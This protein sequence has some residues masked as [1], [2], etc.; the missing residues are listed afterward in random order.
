[1]IYFYS[2]TFPPHVKN[3]HIS[4]V[5]STFHKH[6]EVV[7]ATGD[8]PPPHEVLFLVKYYR[9]FYCML[10]SSF[11]LTTYVLESLYDVDHT[12][13]QSSSFSHGILDTYPSIFNIRNEIF[14]CKLEWIYLGC[15]ISESLTEI[16]NMSTCQS[17]LDIQQVAKVI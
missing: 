17:L 8:F 9:Q 4:M 1:M 11:F 5:L 16:R 10:L 15:K 7:P 13:C 14:E 3:S 2:R 12:V 6:C